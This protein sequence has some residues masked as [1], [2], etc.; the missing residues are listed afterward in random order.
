MPENSKLGKMAANE[1]QHWGA[2]L[3]D[4][5]HVRCMADFGQLQSTSTGRKLAAWTKANG[6]DHAK[7]ELELVADEED[8]KEIFPCD[9]TK[10]VEDG[11]MR[12]WMGV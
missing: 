8:P 5:N 12:E 10:L 6:E 3:F 7:E 2:T 4:F 9:I 1:I 11:E